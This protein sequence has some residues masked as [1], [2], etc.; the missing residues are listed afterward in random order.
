MTI[1]VDWDIKLQTKQKKL[2]HMH[3]CLHCDI[4][5]QVTEFLFP[6]ETFYNWFVKPE[7]FILA[8]FR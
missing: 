8:L 3:V 2:L 5:K 4:K 1:A 6:F 7:W